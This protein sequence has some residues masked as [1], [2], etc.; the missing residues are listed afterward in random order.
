MNCPS[1]PHYADNNKNLNDGASG[2]RNATYDHTALVVD[3]SPDMLRLAAAMLKTLGYEVSLA[4][5]GAQA[6]YD[7]HSSPSDLVLTDYEMP[8]INGYQLGRRIKTANP[9]T[10]VVIMTGLCRAAVVGLMGDG[11]ID[12]WLFK[13]FQMK[14]LS[15]LLSRLGLPP[16]V[17]AEV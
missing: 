12:G 1:H 2:N 14:E 16:A 13:P 4:A 10:R 11:R 3:D 7:F 9:E 17:S 8:A 6:L 15:V 5:E